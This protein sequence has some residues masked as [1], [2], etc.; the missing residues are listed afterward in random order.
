M[1]EEPSSILG[2]ALAAWA[3]P[4]CWFSPSPTCSREEAERQFAQFVEQVCAN[5]GFAIV[6]IGVAVE[7]EEDHQ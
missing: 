4:P 1:P 7:I 5:H 2:K 6:P 3:N